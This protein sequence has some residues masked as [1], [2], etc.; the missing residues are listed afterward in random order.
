MTFAEALAQ[1]FK[2]FVT[3]VSYAFEQAKKKEE[4]AADWRARQDAFEKMVAQALIEIRVKAELEKK[5][6]DVV[7]DYLDKAQASAQKPVNQDKS[8]TPRP[9]AKPAS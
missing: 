2:L 1:A 5:Q 3:V 4:R 6:V 8:S 7:D 9:P